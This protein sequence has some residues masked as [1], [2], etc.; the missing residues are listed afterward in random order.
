[1]LLTPGPDTG[2]QLADLLADLAARPAQAEALGARARDAFL[3]RFERDIC[4]AQ[5]AD[6]LLNRQAVAAAPAPAGR[7]RSETSG[8]NAAS[9]LQIASS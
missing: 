5:W 3:R 2:A 8:P 9:H 7:A 1:M 6:L 4:C